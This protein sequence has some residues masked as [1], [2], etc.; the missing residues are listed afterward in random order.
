MR[1]PTDMPSMQIEEQA[2]QDLPTP[3]RDPDADL[4]VGEVFELLQNQRR[5]RVLRY[6]TTETDNRATLSDLAEHVAG[7]END[8]PPDRVTSTQRKRVY[9]GHYQAH[10]P[11]LDDYGVV[12]FDKHRG[13]VDLRDTTDLDPY[14]EWVAAVEND[15]DPADVDRGFRDGATDPAGDGADDGD[16]RDLYVATV[17][18]AVVL[19]GLAGLGP[20]SAVS[21]GL[22]TLVSIAALLWIAVR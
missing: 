1:P 13:T 19:L 22:W 6:L 3:S 4:G 17:T 10:L 2:L 16:P 5:R 18:T 11:K 14:L 9:V 20:L 21:G 12:D 15:D 8:V 7:L